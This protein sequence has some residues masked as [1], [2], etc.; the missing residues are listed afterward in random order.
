MS[1]IVIIILKKVANIYMILEIVN[2][3]SMH[4]HDH[5]VY[6]INA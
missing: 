4:E 5:E 1:S 6:R 2:P 3:P